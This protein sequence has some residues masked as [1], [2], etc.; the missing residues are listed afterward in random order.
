[1]NIITGLAMWRSAS[2]TDEAFGNFLRNPN[3][4]RS[5]HPISKGAADIMKRIFVVNP[6]ARI[7][8]SELREEIIKLD[9]FFMSEEDLLQAPLVVREAAVNYSALGCSS[10]DIIHPHSTDETVYGILDEED[11]EEQYLFPSPDPDAPYPYLSPLSPRIISPM[12]EDPPIDVVLA[13]LFHESVTKRSN[14]TSGSCSS[15]ADSDGPITPETHAVDPA[16]EVPEFA[17]GENLDQSLVFTD[18]FYVAS[19]PKSMPRASPGRFKTAM[20]RMKAKVQK[21]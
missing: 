5:T 6:L 12:H 14:S 4:I 18:P 1:M 19:T 20:Q 2:S 15:G 8:L 16:I 13:T 7:T 9:T 21:V 3:I 10:S 11:P 17:D